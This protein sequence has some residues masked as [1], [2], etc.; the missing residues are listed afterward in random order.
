MQIGQGTL[1]IDAPPLAYWSFLVLIPFHGLQRDKPLYLAHPQRLSTGLWQPLLLS[2]PGFAFFSR[3]S[4]FTSL[5]CLLSGVIIFLPLLFLQILYFTPGPNTWRLTIISYEKRF[6]VKIS[7]LVLFQALIILW[8]CLPSH[9]LLLHFFLFVP[10][11]W[12][13]HPPSV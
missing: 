6:F 7:V 2:F 1:L 8:M 9:Y 10:N 11:F 13:I 12:W 4:D 3:N 5:M